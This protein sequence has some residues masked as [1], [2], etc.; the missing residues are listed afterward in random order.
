MVFRVGAPRACQ[1][2]PKDRG[3]QAVQLYEQI[4]LKPSNFR[5]FGRA[6][7]R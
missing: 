1:S 2:V 3:F 7:L 6:N 4:A 5:R